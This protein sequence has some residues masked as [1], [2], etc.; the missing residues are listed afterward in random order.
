MSIEPGLEFREIKRDEFGNLLPDSVDEVLRPT[1]S[2]PNQETER[3]AIRELHSKL[4]AST[5]Q[6]IRE[7]ENPQL[8]FSDAGS[9]EAPEWLRRQHTEEVAALEAEVRRLQSKSESAE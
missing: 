4:D 5:A 1:F 2:N 8:S 9:L 3:V 7:Q 6:I